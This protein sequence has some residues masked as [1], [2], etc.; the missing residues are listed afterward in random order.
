MHLGPGD[1]TQGCGASF[2]DPEACMMTVKDSSQESG[3]D[4][5]QPGHER[6]EDEKVEHLPQGYTTLTLRRPLL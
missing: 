3:W 5:R 4:S 6:K 2:Y 1:V